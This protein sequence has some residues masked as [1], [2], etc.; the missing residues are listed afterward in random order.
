MKMKQAKRTPDL[1]RIKRAILAAME[2]SAQKRKDDF[3]QQSHRT[4][5][6]R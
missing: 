6:H 4:R 3:S 2:E 1:P 5:G